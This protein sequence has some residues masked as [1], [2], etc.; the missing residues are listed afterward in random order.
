MTVTRAR[1]PASPLRRTERRVGYL[2]VLPTAALFVAFVGWPIAHSVYLSLTSWSGFGVPRFTGIE[3]YARMAGDDVFR[4]ALVITV[5]FTAVTTVLQT[6][7]PMLVAI[8]INAGWRRAGVV[9]RTILFL[10]GIISLVVTGVLWQLIYDPN[11]GTLNAVL[12]D[13]GLESWQQQW[14]GDP[15]LVVPAIVVVSLWQSLG[16]YMLIFFAGLQGIDP[17]LYEAARVDGANAWQRLRHVTVPMLRTVTGVVVA[18][19]LINGFKTFDIVYVMTQGGPNHSSEVLGT[20]LYSLAFGSLSG[21]IPQIGY[22]TAI[23]IVVMALCLVAAV[24][25]FAVNR[26]ATAHVR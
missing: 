15:N 20:Y 23:S 2:F 1:P 3:N 16:L 17:T 25:Q 6:V 22:A 7:L 5:V 26:R 12:G 8:L 4:T 9:F 14:L 13:L 19:N 21:S 11:L 24:V 18:L 10:P